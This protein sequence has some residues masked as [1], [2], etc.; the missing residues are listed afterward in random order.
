IGDAPYIIDIYNTDN[1]P[2]MGTFGP[3]TPTGENIT[4]FPAEDVCVTY[5][6][7]T[8][9]GLTT[10]EEPV[11]GPAPPPGFTVKQY[12]IIET[13][14][15][16]TGNISIRIIY[17]MLMGKRGDGTLQEGWQLQQCVMLTGDVD[18]DFDVDIFD[19]VRLAGRYGA[20]KPDPRYDPQCDL[21]HD[22][23]IDIFDL[24][25]MAVNYGKVWSPT[26]GWSDITTRV[27]EENN[28]IFGVTNSLSIFGVTV[29]S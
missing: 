26:T 18:E 2:L 25:A 23:D 19:L 21:D 14:A 13:T 16:Y 12:Y 11:T 1:Y 7:V 15:D 28:S 29:R 27:D 10:V 3:S 22:G 8:S 24:V 20:V 9:E 4:V 6:A 17:N 5:Q